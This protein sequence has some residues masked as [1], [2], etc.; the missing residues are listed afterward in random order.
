MSNL[1]QTEIIKFQRD[2]LVSDFEKGFKAMVVYL[3]NKFQLQIP[4]LF[5]AHKLT[6]NLENIPKSRYEAK[7]Y[8]AKL[9]KVLYDLKKMCYEKK[10]NGLTRI[11]LPITANIE[12]TTQVKLV[13]DLHVTIDRLMGD[14]LKLQQYSFIF[15][16]IDFISKSNFK[17]EFNF[18][19]DKNFMEIGISK[20]I[21]YHALWNDFGNKVINI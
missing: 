19:K 13:Y 11:L 20:Y 10:L 12:F 21:F 15:K 5:D 16:E 3:N 17:D 1:T 6:V 7:F 14:K 8:M 2:A 4:E 9:E 18:F